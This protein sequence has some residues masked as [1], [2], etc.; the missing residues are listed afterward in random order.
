MDG[1]VWRCGGANRAGLNSGGTRATAQDRYGPLEVPRPTHICAAQR[2]VAHS[3]YTRAP[4]LLTPALVI[5]RT[6]HINPTNAPL[7]A[8]ANRH[9]PREMR[10]LAATAAA[11]A[12]A[13]C[14]HAAAVPPSPPP[15]ADYTAFYEAAI[16]RAPLPTAAAALAELPVDAAADDDDVGSYLLPADA[17]ADDSDTRALRALLAALHA[18]QHPP[19]AACRTS[20]LLLTQFS[21]KSFEGLGSIVKLLVHGLAE[22]AH[23]NRTLVWGLDLPYMFEHSRG[24][25]QPKTPK[26]GGAAP[27][28]VVRA[29]GLELE[30]GG[31]R[32]LGGGPYTCLFAPLSSCSLADVTPAELEGLGTA[33]GCHGDEGR[34]RVQEARRGPSAFHPPYASAAFGPLFAGRPRMA[35]P[36]HKWAAALAA[37]AF[38]LKPGVVAQLEMHRRDVWA[39]AGV[40][41]AA[42]PVVGAA[43]ELAVDAGAGTAPATAAPAAQ[44]P[45]PGQVWAVHVRHG[46]VTALADIY[47][48]RRVYSFGQAIAAAQARAAAI[49]AAGGGGGGGADVAAG[50]RRYPRLPT[51]VFVASDDPDTDAQLAA[52]AAPAVAAKWPGGAADAPRLFTVPAALRY[53]TAHGSHTVAADGGCVLDS[54]ALHAHDVLAYRAQPAQADVPRHDRIM[55]VLSE[56]AADLYLLSA[57]GVGTLV[58]QA[59]S[60]FST[61]AVLLLWARS[62]ARDPAS[63]YVYLDDAPVSEGTLQCSLLHGALNGTAAVPPGRGGER[64]LSHTR[65]FV[66]GLHDAATAD[67]GSGAA[68]DVAS[69]SLR[70]GLVDGLPLFP[71]DTFY[72]EAARWTGAAPPPSHVWPGE[73]PL[74]PP[75]TGGTPLTATQLR[76]HVAALV[77]TGADHSDLHP[78]QAVRCWRAAEALLT[79]AAHPSAAAADS[80]PSDAVAQLLDVVE[81]NLRATLTQHCF[82]YAGLPRDKVARF[83]E[84]NLGRRRGSS[85]SRR[86]TSTRE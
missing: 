72:R 63:A 6:L 69:P 83:L 49:A 1:V 8:D 44:A 54:C 48:N 2:T 12:A 62:A 24:A 64:W 46:D 80:L 76:E 29:G 43:A 56:A 47:G 74:A 9:P 40:P 10:A 26:E 78:G 23:A 21:P 61:M 73:C 35:H 65:R 77:N 25:W 31:W 33:D 16:A 45:L 4:L 27:S 34:V 81:G 18:Q 38:R 79:A 37:Y 52:Q 66:E 14:V 20:R 59:S 86:S 41:T 67:S 82:P 19:K 32:G 5:K 70:L 51:A 84:L 68:F 55:R 50:N 30:C 36:R 53:R 71:G 57:P 15:P 17:S 75:A 28:R 60:H 11:L 42:S 3:G 39:A 22:A 58:T 7:R 85:S 13:L